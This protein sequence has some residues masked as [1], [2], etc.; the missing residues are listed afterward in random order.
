MLLLAEHGRDQCVEELFD[1]EDRHQ[2]LRNH[3]T[4][5]AT[6]ARS[7]SKYRVW[8]RPPTDGRREEPLDGVDVAC[9]VRRI[10]R[11]CVTL[12]VVE[13]TNREGVDLNEGQ[14]LHAMRAACRSWASLAGSRSLP[15]RTVQDLAADLL[16]LVAC[17]EHVLRDIRAMLVRHRPLSCVDHCV[18]TTVE[19]ALSNVL[20]RDEVVG[21]AAYDAA[22]L[23]ATPTSLVS[24][25]YL[26]DLL[27]IYRS[28]VL[29][30]AR[31]QLKVRG[32]WNNNLAVLE[33]ADDML[34]DA[35][36]RAHRQR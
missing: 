20:A 34:C 33:R 17:D 9:C 15:I 10:L 16:G 31:D 26:V 29:I 6:Q 24:D 12:A 19:L 8:G 23:A 32:R 7:A 36:E 1:K 18:Y 30:D 28:D 13:L 27:T 35:I 2:G 22:F 14:V 11:R 21:A 25:I 5:R 3:H 4:D